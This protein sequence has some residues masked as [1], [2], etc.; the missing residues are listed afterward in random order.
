MIRRI[1]HILL[2]IAISSAAALAA[3]A[4]G[5]VTNGTTGKPAAGVEVTL[6]KLTNGMEEAGTVKT[7]AQGRF[8]LKNDEP[9]GPHV[10]RVI[11]QGV[12]YMQPLPPGSSSGDITIYESSKS[13]F[14]GI[15]VVAH[16]IRFQAESGQLQ[17]AELFALQNNATPARTWQADKTFEFVLPAGAQIQGTN[18]SGPGGMP[19]RTDTPSTGQKDHYAFAFP[20][21][22]GESKLQIEYTL[23]YSGQLGFDPKTLDQTQHIVIMLPHSMSFQAKDAANFQ[24][25]NEEKDAT[26]M[27]ASGVTPGEALPFTIS[28]TGLIQQDDQGQGDTSA[29]GGAMQ[30]QPD[31]RPGGGIG[32]PEDTPDPLTRYR[33]GLLIAFGLALLLGALYIV[34]RPVQQPAMAAVG[35]LPSPSPVRTASVPRPTPSTSSDRL[36]DAL[37]DELFDLE[38]ERQQGKISEAEYQKSKAALDQTIAHAVSRKKSQRA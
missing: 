32:A 5:T 10:L 14:S 36:L 37:K 23:P 17:V 2:A 1:A 34:K 8:T 19:I 21:R 12:N 33:W 16:V 29:G 25:M 30:A 15:N 28:G 4:T 24:P 3:D 38:I 18:A 35:D 27:V 7:D 13:R 20:I 22:P 31:N 9:Q 11:Y 6:L 26:V